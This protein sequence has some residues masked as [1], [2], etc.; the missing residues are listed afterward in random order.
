MPPIRKKVIEKGPPGRPKHEVWTL[1]FRRVLKHCEKTHRAIHAAFCVIC[2]KVLCN[3]ASKRL[4][5]HRRICSFDQA[6][7]DAD[8][9]LILKAEPEEKVT[10]I[11]TPDNSTTITFVDMD[12]SNQFMDGTSQVTTKTEY[13][14]LDDPTESFEEYKVLPAQSFND[15]RIE[16]ATAKFFIGCNIPF[17][18]AD[19]L[20]FQKFCRALNP[21][22]KPVTSEQ[23]SGPLLDNVY[24][25]FHKDMKVSPTS[26]LLIDGWSN[27][28]ANTRNVTVMIKTESNETIFLD[29]HEIANVK[30][31]SEEMTEITRLSMAEA[32]EQFKTEVYAVVMGDMACPI[33]TDDVPEVWQFPCNLYVMKALINDYIPQD[34]MN[35]ICKILK[36]LNY[37]YKDEDLESKITGDTRWL[38]TKS[39]LEFC[40]A[41]IP[42]IQTLLS[43][44]SDVKLSKDCKCLFF[45][46]DFIQKINSYVT[47]MENISEVI[48]VCQNPKSSIA[49]SAEQW[50]SLEIPD[51]GSE[52]AQNMISRRDSVLTIQ[53]LV[54][55]YVHPEY[56]GNRLSN[57]QMNKVEEFLLNELD[58]EGL[59]SLQIY[60]KGDGIFRVLNQKNGLSP[61]TY[62]SLA[63]RTHTDFANLCLKLLN[64]PATI[65][66]NYSQVFNNNKNNFLKADK[67]RKLIAVYYHLKE[68]EE[69]PEVE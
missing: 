1:G 5:A 23:L 7:E 19:S 57:D 26:V 31:I 53:C 4:A 48:T 6:P 30:D 10:K 59:N 39:I 41:N 22:C 16:M 51:D 55:N 35:T 49:D 12:D 21:N 44:D 37:M 67:L 14:F 61:Q 9:S 64:V 2:S 11:V 13:T 40:S 25:K 42:T 62:W 54:A 52:I 15:Q 32:L 66:A 28:V 47:F 17:S 56:R 27:G 20:Y 3:T 68:S 24:S 18:A 46:E 38:H 29:N 58:S 34:F 33:R 60:V 8:S 45:D 50:L 36:Q 43:E 63:Q 65:T 69:R